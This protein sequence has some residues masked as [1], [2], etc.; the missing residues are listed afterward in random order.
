VIADMDMKQKIAGYFKTQPIEKAWL[1]GSHSRGDATRKSDVDIL[2]KFTP[3]SRIGLFKHAGMMLDLQDI[4]KKKVDL[5][6][7]GQLANFAVENVEQEK[8]LIYERA[9]EG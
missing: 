9:V 3:D 8:I 1:F 7:D 2:V 4:L 6:E 5:V